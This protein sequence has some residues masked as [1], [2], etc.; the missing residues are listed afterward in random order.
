M[1]EEAIL[2]GIQEANQDHGKGTAIEL[3]PMSPNYPFLAGF[4]LVFYLS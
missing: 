2:K 4:R 3:T 1:W